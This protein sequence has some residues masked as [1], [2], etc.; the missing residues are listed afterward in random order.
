M[1]RVL[2]FGAT[3]SIGYPI[4]RALRR[5]GHTVYGVVRTEEKALDLVKEEITPILAEVSEVAAWEPILNEVD[6]VIDSSASK[7]GMS[8]EILNAIK[9]SSRVKNAK[10]FHPK[11]GFIYVSG[12]WVHGDS[13]KTVTDRIPVGK[14]AVTPPPELIAWRTGFEDRVLESRDVLDVAILRAGVVFGV[15]RT[16]L[17]VW[18]APFIEA[19]KENKPRDPVTIVGNPEAVIGL[20]HKDDY[21]EAMLNAV[22]KFEI[23]SQ[24]GYPIFDI[25]SGHEKLERLNKT[26]AEILEITGEIKYQEP[27]D[28]FNKALNTSVVIDLSRSINYLGWQPK[29]GHFGRD[30]ELYVKSFLYRTDYYSSMLAQLAAAAPQSN[31]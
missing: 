25:V 2:L 22:E 5:Q 13:Q 27:T 3:G 8:D 20:V 29:H 12:I 6:I 18:W 11:I 28:L 9:G 1:V 21:A 14:D 7:D 15:E 10:K 16:L 19:L 30:A 23:I 4:A 26:A 17:G 24:I 31:A